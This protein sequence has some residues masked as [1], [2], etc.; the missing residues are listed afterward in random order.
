MCRCGFGRIL[1][2]WYDWVLMNIGNRF[3][4]VW[5]VCIVF[6][7][8]GDFVVVCVFVGGFIVVVV[9]VVDVVVGWYGFFVGIVLDRLYFGVCWVYCWIVVVDLVDWCGVDL[10]FW[11]LWFVLLLVCWFGVCWFV[12][13]RVC[14]WFGFFWV[15]VVVGFVCFGVGIWGWIVWLG[16]FVDYCYVCCGIGWLF[17]LY[18]LV[19]GCLYWCGGCV[20]VFLFVGDVEWLDIFVGKFDG[21]FVDFVCVC[22]GVVVDLYCD[23]DVVGGYCCGWYVWCVGWVGWFGVF[24]VVCV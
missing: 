19:S 15:V 4:D 22:V 21:F 1:C 23:V 7:F 8:V 14:C 18:Y 20:W 9:F 13:C 5:G 24:G 11:F 10:C 2:L 17:G 3:D 6:V 12:D 16:W